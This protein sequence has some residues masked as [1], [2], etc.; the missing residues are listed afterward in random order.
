TV[1]AG[2]VISSPVWA[3]EYHYK[4]I[5]VGDRAAGLGGA[6]TAV[7]DDASGLYYNPAGIVYAS[8]PKISGSVNAYNYKTTEYGDIN[9]SGHKWTRTSSGMVANYFGATQP[10]GDNST[11][12]FSIA[13]PNYDLEDQ[14]D[15]FTSFGASAAMEN[16]GYKTIDSQQIDYNNEDSTTLAGLSYATSINKDFSIG[17]TLY[18]YM[19][20][21]EMTNMQIVRTKNDAGDKQ[22]ED[23]LYQKVQTQELGIQPRLGIMWAPIPKLSIGMMVQTTFMLSEDPKSR[24]YIRKSI[25]ENSGTSFN[26]NCSIE[27]T[28]YDQVT[29][30]T[31]TTD[32]LADSH[33]ESPL[34]TDGKND[35]P[36]ETNLGLAYFASDKLMYTADLSYSSETDTYNAVLNAAGGVEYFYN[37]TWA[38][39]GGLY[40]NMANTSSKQEKGMNPYVNLFGTS[41]SLSRYTKG[42]N[43]T[44]GMNYSM[45]EGH[46][47]LNRF[48]PSIQ[49]I[50]VQSLNLFIST[51][52]SF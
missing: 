9:A 43:I 20:K 7:A 39:R 32:N 13:I 46:A 28:Y 36:I 38:I 1:L 47:D 25:C 31:L 34:K 24:T 10:L 19:R 40:T 6:Y 50:S 23:T 4:D 5:L 21:K 8:A 16:L 12:G 30:S 49:T 35:L 26:Q 15:E 42:S 33:F 52:A 22:L 27:T 41:V 17:L 18:G 2:L 29:E 48:T 3:D 44:V 45:G 14:S 37:P 51:S 11:V